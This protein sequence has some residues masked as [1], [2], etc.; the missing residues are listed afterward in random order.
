MTEKLGH[1]LLEDIPEFD[2][3]FECVDQLWTLGLCIGGMRD[4]QI[5]QPEPFMVDREI[6]KSCQKIMIFYWRG[7]L[8]AKAHWAVP[9]HRLNSTR[10]V[11]R[12]K[13]S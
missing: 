6:S 1:D 10:Q 11:F 7:Q 3:M 12:D 2:C 9:Q 5:T 13:D 4:R 8:T